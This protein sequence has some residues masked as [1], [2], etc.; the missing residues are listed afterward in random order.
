MH[1]PSRRH[2]REGRCDGREHPGPDSITFAN[3]SR[4]NTPDTNTLGQS[5]PLADTHRDAGHYGCSDAVPGSSGYGFANGYP[6]ADRDQHAISTHDCDSR[7][8]ERHARP[9]AACDIGFFAESYSDSRA[10]SD[11][12]CDHECSASAGSADCGT[13]RRRP[14]LASE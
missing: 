13:G 11:A 8:N 10:D 4:N 5:S 1:D 14:G 2:E 12:R 7:A 3:A 6:V 9:D